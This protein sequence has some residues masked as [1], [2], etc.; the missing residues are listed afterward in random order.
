MTM[1]KVTV[2]RVRYDTIE[3]DAAVPEMSLSNVQLAY[4]RAIEAARHIPDGIEWKR[5]AATKYTGLK[6]RKVED[7]S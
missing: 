3:V 2:Q 4:S 1:L 7:I 5:T 6:Y